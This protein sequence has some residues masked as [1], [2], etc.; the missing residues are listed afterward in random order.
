M[1]YLWLIWPRQIYMETRTGHYELLYIVP[2]RF[3]DQEIIPIQEKMKQIFLDLDGKIVFDEAWGRKRFAYPIR[4]QYHGYYFLLRFD[5]AKGNLKEANRKIR[6]LNEVM[7]YQ[8]VAT[9][10]KTAEEISKERQEKQKRLLK[11]EQEEQETLKKQKDEQRKT[12]LTKLVPKSIQKPIK[13][14]MMDKK[15][16]EN[17]V[18]LEDLDKK[19]DEILDTKDII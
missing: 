11:I 19:L 10:A 16:D 5:L 1:G 7:R 6:L 13:T 4:Q 9:T 15:E 8:I 12:A 3:T 14:Q 18:N 2:A 17:K